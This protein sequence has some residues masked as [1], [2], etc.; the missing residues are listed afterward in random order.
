MSDSQLTVVALIRAKSQYTEDIYEGLRGLIEPTLPEEGC[1]NYDLH[2]DRDDPAL[3]VFHE[4]W[5]TE[6]HLEQ[7]LESDHIKAFLASAEGKIESV[8]IRKLRRV[9]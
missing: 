4:N 2:Q 8:D 5:E 3:F 1:I 6:W 9:C 7:H